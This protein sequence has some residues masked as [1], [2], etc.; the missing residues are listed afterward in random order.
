MEDRWAIKKYVPLHFVSAEDVAANANQT[1]IVFLDEGR[2]GLPEALHEMGIDTKVRFRGF[3][4]IVYLE[5]S[6]RGH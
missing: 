1:A 4:Q 3:L 2:P 5:P 6:S